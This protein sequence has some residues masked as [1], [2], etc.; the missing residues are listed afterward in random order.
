MMWN[1]I[2]NDERLHLWKN[3]R[4]DIKSKDLE[5]QL[6]EIAQFCKFMPYGARTLDYYSPTDW[7]T[8]WEILYHGSFCTSSISLLMFYTLE[9]VQTPSKLELQLVEDQQDIYLMPVIDDHFVLNYQLGAVSI[10]P[11]IQNSFKVIKTFPQQE[12]KIIT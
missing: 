5:G 10:Y 6:S 9:L 1:T 12:I 3:L 8:P 4:D 2:P 7:P 11:E